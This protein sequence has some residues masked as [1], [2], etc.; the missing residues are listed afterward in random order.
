M[1]GTDHTRAAESRATAPHAAPAVV[2][3]EPQL[4]ENIGATAR[5]MLNFGLTDMRLVAPRGDWPNH[6]ALNTASGAES[7]LE[8]AS[9]FD[10]TE[11][12]I[13][14]LSFVLAATARRRDMIKPVVTPSEAAARLRQKA[15]AGE[16]T[17][18]MFG[19]ERSGLDNDDVARADALLIVPANPA[20]SSINLAQAVLL[21]AYEWYQ[22][23]EDVAPPEVTRKGS[24]PASKEELAHFYE[25]L[26]SEL[27]ACG[28][29]HP[30]DKR[31]RMVRNI[32]NI[33]ARADL[34]DQEVRTL[35]GIVVG[36]TRKWTQS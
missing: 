22:R 9:L 19:R 7:V 27:D 30:P 31:P 8:N 5:A 36:L 13:A 23:G 34:T 2:L 21:V 16:P 33:F 11:D 20:H 26:E 17:G 12:A 14:D 18:L 1:A 3:V 35:R 15:A 6:K 29:L 25:H 4:G 10:A 24:Q 28:F 32:R